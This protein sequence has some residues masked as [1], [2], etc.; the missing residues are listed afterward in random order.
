MPRRERHVLSAIRVAQR[1][2][3]NVDLPA[4]ARGRDRMQRFG[5]LIDVVVVGALFVAV[6]AMEALY[7]RAMFGGTWEGWAIMLAVV[8]LHSIKPRLLVA[9]DETSGWRKI[10]TGAAWALLTAL[11][12]VAAVGFLAHIRHDMLAARVG[13]KR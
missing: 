9:A 6:V 5:K 10:A 3:I 4:G 2:Q 11:S 8:A 12:F 1:H 7:A 13:T